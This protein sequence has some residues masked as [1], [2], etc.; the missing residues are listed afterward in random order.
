MVIY[1]ITVGIMSF[2]VYYT[3]LLGTNRILG[4]QSHLIRLGLGALLGAIH[5]GLCVASGYRLLAGAFWNVI[6]L[7]LGGM[8][9]FGARRDSLG[10][11]VLYAVLSMGISW[12]TV[13]AGGGQWIRVVG[14][15]GIF[16]LSLRVVGRR[17]EENIM[18]VEI[19]YQNEKVNIWALRDT[20]NGLK[21]PITGKPVLVVG[22]KVAQKLLGLT[23]QQL[24]NPVD[25][26]G[27]VPG[28]RLI[29]YHTIGKENGLLLGMRI[30]NTRIGTWQGST[31]VAFAPYGLGEREN[32]QAL[33]GGY[34]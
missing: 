12:L 34:L 32:Y 10:K 33:T 3:L 31:I 13:A 7:F 8:V 19:S 22:P 6:C 26:V 5:S 15:L 14:A 23:Q 18:S 29:P 4:A 30:H 11:C 17:K 1:G 9:A 25:S 24:E 20:G 28:L 2:A 21:D 16:F 27:C